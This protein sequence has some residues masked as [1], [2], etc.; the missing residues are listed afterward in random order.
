MRSKMLRLALVATAVVGM[1]V[2]E[3]EDLAEE[4]AAAGEAAASAGAGIEVQLEARSR[5][6]EATGL[7]AVLEKTLSRKDMAAQRSADAKKRR[8]QKIVL[9]TEEDVKR[10]EADARLARKKE[11]EAFA[12][13]NVAAAAEMRA[14]QLIEKQKVQ[15]DKSWQ[16]AEY[17]DAKEK[18]AVFAK[19]KEVAERAAAVKLKAEQR[20][21]A[22]S[23]AQ[24]RGWA[25]V[26]T[27]EALK[28]NADEEKVKFEEEEKSASAA[29]AKKKEEVQLLQ[30]VVKAAGDKLEAE[31]RA[32]MTGQ[33][34]DAANKRAEDA[35]HDEEAS[36]LAYKLEDEK[37]YHAQ[38]T[39]AEGDEKA[40]EVARNKL[41]AEAS[42]KQ[43]SVEMAEEEANKKDDEVITFKTG[44]ARKM[45]ER[46]VEAE[47]TK[48]AGARKRAETYAATA[49]VARRPIE[50]EAA[51]AEA[52]R[53]ASQAKK[54]AST[55]RLIA[56]E[57]K[58]RRLAERAGLSKV[59]SQKLILEDTIKQGQLR[60][61]A[62]DEAIKSAE[63]DLKGESVLHDAHDA[64]K[65]RYENEESVAVAARQHAA[66]AALK[67]QQN[68]EEHQKRA[69]ELEIKV[70]EAERDEKFLPC[71]NE[72][73]VCVCKGRVVYGRRFL[74]GNDGEE[75]TFPQTLVN[76]VRVRPCGSS[77]ICSDV[78]F[79]DP[80]PG[81]KKHCFCL[82]E[83]DA[84][85]AVED[86]H[87]AKSLAEEAEKRVHLSEELYRQER[88][89]LDD[90]IESNEQLGE[91]SLEKAEKENR[92]L[93]NQ[94][95][96]SENEAVRIKV[97][98][99]VGEVGYD[100]MDHHDM[101]G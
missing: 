19:K 54:A 87:E 3:D 63:A 79:G 44:A 60:A 18:A 20:A 41:K 28:K 10:E 66:E 25:Q 84:V 81:Y 49:A 72:D 78:V 12:A 37:K 40:L 88:N 8:A 5:V 64:A 38:K 1:R 70:S 17:W 4:A 48:A 36:R 62:D 2:D 91:K 29:A 100:E 59:E 33:K 6:G 23:T 16:E 39:K 80:A 14:H 74:D 47:R 34:E 7:S 13:S 61:K 90:W 65:R 92:K 11:G 93:L 57:V 76:S 21:L 51:A 68:E 82:L 67:Y 73:G 35:A 24:R 101:L 58:A 83:I 27:E 53:A 32:A 26:A 71:A 94:V 45:A 96:K 55:A 98:H 75:R 52:Q 69:E 43:Q 22:A 77:L 30:H 42:E 56:D 85:N 89:E 97:E 15:E 46:E 9:T 99:G 86:A 31:V 95:Q 50:K